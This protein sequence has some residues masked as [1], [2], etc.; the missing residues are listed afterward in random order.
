MTDAVEFVVLSKDGCGWCDRA[1]ELLTHGYREIRCETADDLRRELTERGH[2]AAADLAT[3]FPQVMHGQTYVGGYRQLEDYL[4]EPLLGGGAVGV[5]VDASRRFTPFPI[6]YPDLW[7]MYKRAVASFWTTEEVNLAQDVDDWKSLTSD[8]RHFIKHVLAFFAGAD[9]IVMENL[10][11]N[12]GVEVKVPEARQ[13]Y[14]FQTFNESQH[15]VAP[16]TLILTDTGY[17]QIKELNAKQ[18]RVWNGEEWSTTTVQKTGVDQPLLKVELSNGMSLDCT[19]EHK[20]FVRKGPRG[21]PELSHVE[22]V[23]TKD[24]EVGDVIAKYQVPL[25]DVKDPD[26]FLNPYTHGAFCGDGMYCNKYPLLHLYGPK[27]DLLPFLEVSSVNYEPDKA[28]CSCYLTHKMNKDKF[29]VPINYSTT[30]KLRW[31]EGLCDT[32][33]C[34]NWNATKTATN[35]QIS[36]VNRKFIGD[37]QLMLTT[38][39]VQAKIATMHEERWATM[40][41]GK[42]GSRE[43]W[44]QKVYVMYITGQAVHSLVQL[45]FAPHRLQIRTKDIVGN[46]RL[47]KV[48][49][50]VDEERISD[51]YCFNEPIRHAGVFNGILT[52]QS[53]QYGLLIDTLIEDPKERAEVFGAIET[54]PAVRA[55]AMWATK[56]LNPGRRFAERLLAFTCVEGILFSGSFC[57]IFWLKQR[58]VMPGL[59]LSNQFISRDEGLHQEF[60]ALVYSYL[61]SPLTQAEAEAIV[62]EAVDNEKQFITQ[63]IPCR[64]IGMNSDMMSQY[65]EF[66]ADRL[67]TSMGY[68]PA[69]KST[70]PFPWMELLSLSAKDNFFERFSSEYQKAGIMASA[71]DQTFGLDG[72]F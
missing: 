66:V 29:F 63:A 17:H 53:E 11:L 37:V 6:R 68:A 20:W 5:A 57:A 60:G 70:N 48:E 27:Q 23:M 8:E 39:G 62:T 7:G 61:E 56:W 9:G 3:T 4:R 69:Y 42:G 15:C 28:R 24:L 71:E 2:A 31:L 65:I 49:R 36:N 33:G 10:Q 16:E 34:V 59:G 45:G 51:T 72:D 52:G 14:A 22:R 13:F 58:G 38:L 43:Y 35:I 1:K 55:K 19:T 30:T 64:L 21:H 67:L 26:E 12:F 44:C 25:L 18:V 40:P 47:I 46:P 50:I 32:D 54:M 41:D